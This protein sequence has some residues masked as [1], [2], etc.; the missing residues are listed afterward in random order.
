MILTYTKRRRESSLAPFGTKRRVRT[1]MGHRFE[2]KVPPYGFAPTDGRWTRRDYLPVQYEHN[3]YRFAKNATTIYIDVYGLFAAEAAAASGIFAANGA[4]AAAAAPVVVVVGIIALAIWGVYTIVNNIA[5]DATVDEI[6]SIEATK[7]CFPYDKCERWCTDIYHACLNR[8]YYN[9][10]C[11][12]SGWVK[13]N[14][15]KDACILGCSM[16]KW[17]TE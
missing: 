9:K 3:S 7:D 17:P 16:G 14:V 2:K 13:C 12:P 4:A 1:D 8:E 6:E 11:P 5:D 15:A 10:G